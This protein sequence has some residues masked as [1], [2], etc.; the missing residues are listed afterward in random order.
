MRNVTKIA[1]LSLLLPSSVMAQA[2]PP[3]TLGAISNTS[4]SVHLDTDKE[5][6]ALPLIVYQG[7]H[8]YFQGIELGYRL[9]PLQSFHN[10]SFGLSLENESYDPDDSDNVD[11]RKL[12]D[13]DITLMSV[14]AYRIGPV[15]FKA[16]Q[17]IL[18]E[19][20]GFFAEVKAKLRLRVNEIGVSPEIS[21]RYL[22]KKLSNHVY[23][24][25]QAESDRTGGN[26]AAY[27]SGSTQKMSVGVAVNYP[28]TKSAF[29]NLKYTHSR[30]N[31]I[32][33]SPIVEDDKSNAVSI[34]ALMRF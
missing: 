2:V 28:L 24:V 21:Y 13:R 1:L 23:G 33:N 11:V 15:T 16:G 26:I 20:D 8:V 29:V 12:D 10:L 25:S 9:L 34:G 27:D 3:W 17:D 32:T 31:D 30:Y 14:A 18:G 7:E 6:K 5:T 19:H 22:D 4:S